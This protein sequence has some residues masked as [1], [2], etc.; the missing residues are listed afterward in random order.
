MGH[1]GFKCPNRGMDI[2]WNE[3]SEQAWQARLAGMHRPALRQDWGF[4]IALQRLG[5]TVRRAMILDGGKPLAVAQ[6]LQRHGL[7][8][9]GQ[10]QVW[11]APVEPAQKRRVLRRLAWHAGACIITPSE[12]VAGLGIIPLIMPKSYAI[13]NINMPPA[14]LRQNLHSKWRNR[15]LR[16]E[17]VVKPMPLLRTHLQELIA[18]EASQRRTRSY[19][20]LPGTMAFKWPG[21]TLAIGWTSGGAL[22]V[23]M[24]FL[25]HG[26]H[27]TYFLGWANQTAR[28]SFAHG[29]ILWQAA[30]VL[31]T[32]GVEAIDLGDVNSE[33]GANLAR[34]KLG[35]G[36]GLM[37]AGS[38]CL[39]LP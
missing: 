13:W 5:A 38:T 34:Y 6:I 39:V 22:Q 36:A 28:T 25:M 26:R 3:D 21:G 27:A 14:L 4:G 33:S 31:R 8:V 10:G 1:L 30:L 35:T 9:I 7:R 29:P 15:F 12:A 16:A 23:G 18:Q 17:D 11:L 2:Q 32:R 24:V 37:T 19:T 20:N